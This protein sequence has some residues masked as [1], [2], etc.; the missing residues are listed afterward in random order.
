VADP[1][2]VVFNP[3]SGKGRGARLVE[4]VLAAL[5]AGG[6]VEHGL[7]AAKGDEARVAR[8]AVGRGF[9]TIV[10]VGGDGTWGGV[11][12]GILESGAADRVSLGLVPGGTGCDL[13]KSLGI[14][15]RD[16]RACARIIRDGA[17]QRI[18]VGRIE[19]RY[20]VNVAGFGLD[21]AVIEDSWDVRW[22]R[23][24]LLY[25]Y[26]AVR[27]LHR[28][29][30]FPVTMTADQGAERRQEMLM[31]V[32]AN[33]RVFGGGF[34]IAPQADLADGQLDVVVFA[35]MPL[36][37]RLP[38]M[39]KLLRGTHGADPAVRA[40]RGR[41]FRLRFDAPPA[42]ETDGEWNRARSADIAVETVPGALRVL[43]PAAAPTLVPAPVS[44]LG[45]APSPAA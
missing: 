26:C 8:E 28:F 39:M 34:Q 12:N 1:V 33:G 13:A 32:F 21:I 36:R 14:P 44:E 16:V 7:T 9:K 38:I 17:T 31:L 4:P 25:V 29:P 18:D 3:A 5:S 23:G 37:R 42:Y 10:A 19:D 30:G 15:R 43:V 40:E 41:A 11:A 45:D 6:P 35:N 22:L 27:Q 20:F 2:F 24:S